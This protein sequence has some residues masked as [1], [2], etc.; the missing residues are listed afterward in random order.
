MSQ[1]QIQEL[2]TFSKYKSLLSELVRRDIKNKYRNSVLGVL[3]SLLDPLL[4]MIV[5]TIVFSTLFHRVHDYPIYYLTGQ[6]SYT[7]FRSGST[8]AMKSLLGSA[9]IW[10]S[11]YVPKYIYAL[12]A[13]LS[14]FVTFM[15][16]LIILFAIMIVMGVNFT[17]YIIF[18]S[19]P[20]LIILIMAFGAGLI[21][22]TLNVFFRDVE[23]LYSVFCLMLLY[24]LPIFYPADILPAK[25]KFIQTYNPLFYLITCMRDCFYYGKL[26]SVTDILI[27]AV[28]AFV[29]L[30]IGILML[31]KYQDRFILYV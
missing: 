31:K 28:A 27:P 23:H 2:N 4:S 3:W 14:N 29:I 10:K 21:L 22:G 17:V 7:L 30:G 6:L 15:F 26:Y 25:F 5:L 13:V 24:A 12:S 8:Q 11:I 16:S 20:I 1:V 19:L 9:S 18:A